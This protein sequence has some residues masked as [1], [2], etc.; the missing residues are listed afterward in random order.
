MSVFVACLSQNI[1]AVGFCDTIPDRIPNQFFTKE[2]KQLL[3]WFLLFCKK[4]I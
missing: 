4:L 2:K 1:I 3:F